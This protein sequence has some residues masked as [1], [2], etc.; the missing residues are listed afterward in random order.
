MSLHSF[1]LRDSKTS[2][3]FSHGW[4]HFNRVWRLKLCFY[5]SR[6]L[7]IRCTIFFDLLNFEHRARANVATK[8]S[9][10]LEFSSSKYSTFSEM[11]VYRGLRSRCQTEASIFFDLPLFLRASIPH[12]RN[13]FNKECI[14]KSDARCTLRSI[15]SWGSS[16]RNCNSLTIKG[17]HCWTILTNQTKRL[18][19]RLSREKK[20]TLLSL[21]LSRDFQETAFLQSSYM[22]LDNQTFPRPFFFL[23][24]KKKKNK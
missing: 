1:A 4:I 19:E 17:S 8:M 21:L 14:S 16:L 10:S 7:E 12:S 22:K 11:Y 20:K 24:K 3:D 23:R 15:V 18:F 13:V 2:K 9:R 5:N 6:S